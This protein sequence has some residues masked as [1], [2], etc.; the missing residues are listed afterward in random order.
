MGIRENDGGGGG[1]DRRRGVRSGEFKEATSGVAS[2]S[3]ETGLLVASLRALL[4][5]L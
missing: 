5:M 1:G 2:L 3:R 4:L